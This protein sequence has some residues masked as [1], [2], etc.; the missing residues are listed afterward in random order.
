VCVRV[1]G[2]HPLR[3][4]VPILKHASY[5]RLHGYLARFAKG[6]RIRII[7]Y[8]DVCI[9]C[10]H[11]WSH[12]CTHMCRCTRVVG[13]PRGNA[14]L[15][16]VGGSGKQSLAKLS[17]FICGC[18][19][20]QITVTATYGIVDFKE[21]LLA[22]YQK[23]GLKGVPTCFIMTDGQIVNE[24]FLVFLNDFLASGSIPDVLTA[25]AKDEFRNGVRNEAKQAGVQVTCPHVLMCV[26]DGGRV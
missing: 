3:M 12:A 24:K 19:I 7:L 25:E 8:Q 15:V 4:F 18:E 1:S 23:A 22:L 10:A 5:G 2:A 21:N 17:A 14:L 16:G 6:I 9:Y 26:Y 11:T 20:F 13:K